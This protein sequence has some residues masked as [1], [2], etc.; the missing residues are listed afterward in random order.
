MFFAAWSAYKP[1]SYL[2][3][4]AGIFKEHNLL[5][6]V[7]SLFFL[8]FLLTFVQNFMSVRNAALRTNPHLVYKVLHVPFVT[9]S[10]KDEDVIIGDEKEKGV[11]KKKMSLLEEKKKGRGL[12][13]KKDSKREGEKERGKQEDSE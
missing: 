7:C 5:L 3:D 11:R 4:G 6:K 10:S 13:K 1:Y 12:G 8:A 2:S 9:E